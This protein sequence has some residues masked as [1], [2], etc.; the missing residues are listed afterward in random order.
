MIPNIRWTFDFSFDYCLDGIKE[1]SNIAISTLGQLK[2]VD[3]RDM[4]LE[5]LRNVIDTIKPKSII[6]YGFITKDNFETIFGYA[7]SI[8]IQII[9][10]HSKI[11]RYKKEDAIYGTR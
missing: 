4:F 5:G 9:I 8:G 10:P 3:N 1:G 11:D 2:D 7:K 6:A